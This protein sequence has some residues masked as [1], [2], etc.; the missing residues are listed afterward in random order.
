MPI[1]IAAGS[2]ILGLCLLVKGADWLVDGAAALARKVGVS[3]LTIGL[4]IVAFGTSMPELVVNVMSSVT[5]ANDIAIGNVIGSNIANIL[6]ILGIA[7][8]ITNI[9]VQRSTVWN[10]IPLAL[11]AVLLVVIMAN[12]RIVDGYAVSELSRS[13]GLALIAFFLIFLWYISKMQKAEKDDDQEKTAKRSV[14][15]SAGLILAGLLLLITGGKLTVDGAVT[16][17]SS[18]GLSQ[19]FIGLT[20]VAVGTSLPELATSV[21]AAR[22]GKADIA[23][24]NVV[25]SNIFNVFW[26]LGVSAIIKPLTFAPALNLDVLVAILATVVLFFAVHTGYVHHRLIFW[27]QRQNHVVERADGIVMLLLYAAYIGYL[28]WRG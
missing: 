8:T 16:I 3:D 12:D 20:V 6:L 21:I 28:A 11:L 17:A 18:L 23:V 24:G 7:A 1:L 27:K 2:L 14:P 22:K 10:E 26:I 19:A 4:T 5:G 25:G 13:D 15:A 9:A